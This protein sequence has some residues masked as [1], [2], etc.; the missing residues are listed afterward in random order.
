MLTFNICEVIDKQ[1]AGDHA[2]NHCTGQCLEIW[3]VM[4]LSVAKKVTGFC[5]EKWNIAWPWWFI[6]RCRKQATV[7]YI[8]V[9]M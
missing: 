5:E 2:F 8:K 3:V 9:E 7:Y 4:V 1:M 6:M